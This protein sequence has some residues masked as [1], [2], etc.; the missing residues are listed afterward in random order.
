MYVLLFFLLHRLSVS[1][2]IIVTQKKVSFSYSV[3]RTSSTVT[4]AVSPEK[5]AKD[6]S[7]LVLAVPPTVCTTTKFIHLFFRQTFQGENA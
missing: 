7:A 5:A 2:V 6:E 1:S 3:Q 4:K